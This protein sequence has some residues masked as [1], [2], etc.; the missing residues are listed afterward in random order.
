M[1][2]KEGHK[3]G[4]AQSQIVFRTPML[5]DS[6]FL[7][8]GQAQAVVRGSRQLMAST[9]GSTAGK[10]TLLTKNRKKN[11]TGRW[12]VALME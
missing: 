3:E 4:V 5:P 12:P 8:H 1:R 2:H 10:T 11:C 7:Q 9:V 6:R